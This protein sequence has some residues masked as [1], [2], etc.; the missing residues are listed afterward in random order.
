MFD[1]SV[2]LR[3]LISIKVENLNVNPN[4]LPSAE[5]IGVQLQM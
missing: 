4:R 3:P 5:N 1:C 2:S